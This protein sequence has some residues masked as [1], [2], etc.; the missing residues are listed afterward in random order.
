MP[1]IRKAKKGGLAVVFALSADEKRRREGA[2][3]TLN[4][5]SYY[6]I[7]PGRICGFAA[8]YFLSSAYWAAVMP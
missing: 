2:L 6:E 7:F 3:N 4:L 1:F 8:V 5:F